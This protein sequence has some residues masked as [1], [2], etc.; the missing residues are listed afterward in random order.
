MA[1]AET[2]HITQAMNSEKKP[3]L[4]EFREP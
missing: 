4:Y 3:T 2:P 1:F